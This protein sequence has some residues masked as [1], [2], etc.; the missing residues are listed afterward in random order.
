[1]AEPD[2]DN[3]NLDD[4][5]NERYE[6]LVGE[7][8]NR[9][10][11]RENTHVTDRTVRITFETN[12]QFEPDPENDDKNEDNDITIHS[13]SENPIIGIAIAEKLVNIGKNQIIIREVPFTEKPFRAIILHKTEQRFLLDIPKNDTEKT[14]V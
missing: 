7:E 4:L 3:I 6:N 5:V 14:I 11:F 12:D 13:N 10:S 1:M 2:E 9:P 8:K